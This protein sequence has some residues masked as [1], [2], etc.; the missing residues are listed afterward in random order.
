MGSGRAVT[1]MQVGPLLPHMVM[2]M[3]MS[4]RMTMIVI[5]MMAVVMVMMMAMRVRVI[6]TMIMMV[7]I[8]L[9]VRLAAAATHRA[10]HSTSNSLIRISSPPL[11]C[12]FSPPHSGQDA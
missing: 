11:T 3:V 10:H 12:S 5:M 2:V 4:M 6:M 7:V 9:L 8:G 1:E